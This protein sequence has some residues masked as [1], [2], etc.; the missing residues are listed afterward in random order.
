MS[1]V[2]IPEL[3]I[4]PFDPVAL[5]DPLAT[6]TAIRE[7]GSLVWLPRY[8]VYATGRYDVAR[9]IFMDWERFSSAYGTGLTNIRRETPW[10]KPSVILEVDPPAH[11]AARKVLMRALSPIAMK[12]LQARFQAE[13]DAMVDAVVARGSFD[14]ARDL[15]FAFPFKVLPDAV[16]LRPESREHL[17]PY[18]T[19]NF[20]AMGPRN[21]LYQAALEVVEREGT[22][23]FVEWQCARDNIL[24][25]G[26]GEAIYQAAD[27]G[28]IGHDD[29]ALLV[30]T[31]LSAGIDTTILGIGLT[32]WHLARDPAQW[33]RLVDDPSLA[34]AA[35][36]ETLRLTPPSPIIGRTTSRA[37]ELQGVPLPAEQKVLM[38]L[39]AANRDPR[40]WDAPECYDLTRRSSGHLAFGTG[41]HG[42]V[43]QAV[44]RLEAEC[45][46]GSLARR[47]RTLTLTGESQPLL[48][49]WLRGYQSIPVQVQ[50]A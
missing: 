39:G 20:N 31:F 50:P 33:Q 32:L 37:C 34:R 29:A 16:G 44:A 10:R 12:A 8:G 40:R 25:G 30:R 23:A 1:S 38:F 2:V 7:A 43:G 35:F 47:A 46:L 42:C 11:G 41:I 4:D 45:V 9:E 28:E 17:I 27:A 26:F 48:N 3:D 5:A 36:D 13:A 14:A 15:A 49:N 6:D 19:L 21:A 22:F 24:P 18:A